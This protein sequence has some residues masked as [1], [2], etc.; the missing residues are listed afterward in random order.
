MGAEL[1]VRAGRVGDVPVLAEIYNEAVVNSAATFDLAPRS[2]EDMARWFEEHDDEHPLVVG[3]LK[4]RVAGYATLSR[5]RDKAGYSRTAESSVYVHK[6]YRGRGVGTATLGE[7]V[8][9]ARRLG[10]HAVVAGIVTPNPASVALHTKLG[11]RRV[12]K[13]L[14]VGRKLGRWQDVEF[15]QIIFD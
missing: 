10:F 7:A 13:F 6:D 4:G 2:F 3:V 14:E 11:Y 1:T 5:F 15:Y 9:Q 8:R 12:G